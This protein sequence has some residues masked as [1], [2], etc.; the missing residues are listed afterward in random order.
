[1]A[2]VLA[3]SAALLVLHLVPG[4]APRAAYN[5]P[6]LL[7]CLFGAALTLRAAATTR[8]LARA[9]WG[10]L[11]AACGFAAAGAALSLSERWVMTRISAADWMYG[12]S[13]AC[14]ILAMSV[15]P[16]RPRAGRRFAFD[17]TVLAV[18]VLYVW[19]YFAVGATFTAAPVPLD[20]IRLLSGARAVLFVV[21]G[22]WLVQGT[23]GPWRRTYVEL[24]LALVLMNVGTAFALAAI[25]AGAYRP[26][27]WDLPFTVPYLWIGLL[28]LDRPPVSEDG[29]DRAFAPDWSDL[30][31]GVVV[32]LGAI[33]LVPGLEL[34]M[35]LV[36]GRALPGLPAEVQVHVTR[37][38]VILG[39]AATA[40]IALV[41]ALR[42]FSLLGWAE[43]H[44]GE[45]EGAL[46]ASE[47]RYRSLFE[48][49][50]AGVF[51]CT[52]AGRMLEANDALA[53]LLRY[54][55]TE[56]LGRLSLGDLFFIAEDLELA[57]R[58]LA[59]RGVL[60]DHEV[61]LRRR[62][63]LPVWTLA[64]LATVTGEE[65]EATVM[66]GTVVDITERRRAEGEARRL[67]QLK[68]NFLKVASHEMRTPLT[69]LSGYL[70]ILLADTAPTASQREYLEICLRTVR[71]LATVFEDILA[72][73]EISEGQVKLRP[74]P[75]DLREVARHVMEDL[76]PFLARRAQTVSLQ[77]AEGLPPV[78]ADRRRIHEVLSNLVENAIKF[79][80]DGGRIV[81][82]LAA[83]G[84]GHRITVEDS[85]IGFDADELTDLWEAFY[86]GANPLHHSS[87]TYQFK[88]RGP[89]LGLSIAKGYVEAHG[90]R[91]S[92][93]SAGLGQG[94]AFT[95]VLPRA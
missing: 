18:L 90:G 63:G 50:P 60:A 87:G 54:D 56:A 80:P 22:L 38:R 71:R 36:G 25:G 8:G 83:D 39:F 2:A 35:D 46:R 26:G 62:D 3:L 85:G 44:Q 57:G 66:E 92:A 19:L 16:E 89:G 81:I 72:S 84:S 73:L 24:A 78:H 9:F 75:F 34:A 51:R 29:A 17:L 45:R 82:Q 91:I 5:L 27:L 13:S 49:N 37:A 86:A 11:A 58:R 77:A 32:A 7:F 69:V 67:A 55:D 47:G 21:G 6:H 61:R 15:R 95:V 53:R 52:R 94:A 48:R 88:A 70:E 20:W 41:L 68:T 28:A 40:L 59:E 33:A 23:R 74:E 79:T 64:S 12:T 10:A 76:A 4:L 43:R 14:L 65:G 30:R 42:Q 1:V 93:A 31:K